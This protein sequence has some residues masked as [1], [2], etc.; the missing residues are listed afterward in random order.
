MSDNDPALPVVFAVEMRRMNLSNAQESWTNVY[1]LG[2]CVKKVGQKGETQRSKGW[3]WA[4]G[5]SLENS[6]KQLGVIANSPRTPLVSWDPAQLLFSETGP[7][8]FLAKNS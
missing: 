4:R 8:K 7:P 5:H 2:S 6:R 1:L 3:P